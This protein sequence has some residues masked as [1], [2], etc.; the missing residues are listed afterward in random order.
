MDASFKV[1][2]PILSI[3]ED[4]CTCLLC[5][6]II[7]DREKKT[8]VSFSALKTLKEFAKRWA[9]VKPSSPY[10]QNFDLVHDKIKDINNEVLLKNATIGKSV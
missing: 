7:K 1:T 8:N 6:T 5:D 2:S 9:T 4:S 3:T 10:A